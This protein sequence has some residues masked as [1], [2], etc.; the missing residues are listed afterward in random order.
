[1]PGIVGIIGRIPPERAERDLRQ[2]VGIL[3]HEAFYVTGTWVDQTLGIYV[4]W[5]AREGSFCQE[6]PL[7]NECGDK[8]LI[9]S[10]EEFPERGTVQTLKERGHHLKA[11]GP[12]YLVHVSEEDRSFPAG[13]NGRFQGLLIDCSSRTS[14]LFNDRYG[15]NRIYY[16]ESPDA[17]YFSGEAKAILAVRGGLRTL[18]PRSVGEFIS[19]GS[20]LENRTLFKDIHVLPPASAWVFRN[21]RIERKSSYFHPKEWEEQAKVDSETH[22]QELREVFSRNLPRYFNGRERVGM[23][24]TGGLDTRM[25]LACLKADPGSLPCYTFGSMFRENQDVRVARRV[26]K[27]CNQ[28]FQIVTAGQEFLSRFAYY[29][30]RT[31][32]LTDGCTDV[33]LSPVLYVNEKAREIAPVRISGV[34]GGEILRGVRAFKPETIAHALFQPV[35]GP[36]LQQAA[37]TY[38]RALDGHAISFA[39]FKQAPWYHCGVLALEQTVLS[40]RSPFL[41]NDFVRI[42]F[43]ASESA[44][45]RD[46]VSFRMIADGNP[47][48]LRFPTDRGLSG[49]KRSLAGTFYRAGLEFLFKAEYAYDYGMPQLVARIDQVL[50]PFH[51]ER[52]FL[53]RH[54]YYHFRL[55]YRDVLAA[56]VREMLLDSRSLARP[57]IERRA[58][59]K[60]VREHLR[61]ASNHTAEIHKALSLELLHRLFVDR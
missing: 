48:L 55:W 40:V 17:F 59:E 38:A 28:P 31:V 43:R 58:L 46:L 49:G 5:A 60:I 61:G 20:T 29:A 19:C 3:R 32:Y 4:G 56:Y 1:M 23:S 8:I 14:T 15:M 26:T 36:Y 53:G 51:L 34:F 35:M 9:F 7:R 33:G 45:P 22:Y 18:D 37:Q 25:I 12:D 54:K 44:L 13:L 57:Y 39:V 2:M 47:A 11:T 42:A 41:D 10:G 50:S 52:L 30:E 16:H 6:M 27:A 24:V 21:A